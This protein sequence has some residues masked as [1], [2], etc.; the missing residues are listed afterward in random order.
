MKYLKT[1]EDN[2]TKRYIVV[3]K[4]I[5][6][7]WYSYHFM[8]I[9]EIL[10]EYDIHYKIQHHYRYDFK[11]NKLIK[12]DER[13]L[14]RKW[15]IENNIVFESNFLEDCLKYISVSSDLKKYNI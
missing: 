2:K 9:F 7:D 15:Y 4:Q 1:F 13:S 8:D 14:Y 6:Q 11:I 3:E 5:N 10:S 12:Q